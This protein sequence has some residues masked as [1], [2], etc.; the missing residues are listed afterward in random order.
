M[1]LADG[2]PCAVEADGLRVAVRNA[3]GP[4]RLSGLWWKPSDSWAVETWVVETDVRTVYQLVRTA[5]GWA[6]EGV[7]D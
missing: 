3:Q 5:Q 1:C 6:V 7:Y 2:Q 4:F